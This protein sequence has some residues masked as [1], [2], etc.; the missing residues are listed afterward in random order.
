VP[1]VLRRPLL[2]LFL[3]A[4]CGSREAP[5]PDSATPATTA[6]PDKPVTPVTPTP[7]ASTAPPPTLG[8][9]DFIQ[10]RLAIADNPIEVLA[11]GLAA[12]TLK[13]HGVRE[14]RAYAATAP[15]V[16]LLVFRFDDQP[17]LIARQ[18]DLEAMLGAGD[19]DDNSTPPYYVKSTYTGA[20][21]L[22]TGFP[23]HKPVS[24]EMEAARTAFLSRFA[25]EE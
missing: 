11:H 23:S 4:A 24:P 16:W 14:Y 2:T 7:P 1:S 10:A 20:W 18:K 17:A 6:T 9:P 8:L 19:A 21:L 5:T 3:G 12:D 13:A 25:G 15:R 22:V